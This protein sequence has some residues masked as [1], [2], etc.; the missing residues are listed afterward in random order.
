MSKIRKWEFL[1]ATKTVKITGKLYNEFKFLTLCIANLNM[2]NSRFSRPK[3][4]KKY[5][6]Q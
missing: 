1:N 6:Q 3:L 4:I 5:Q 2:S